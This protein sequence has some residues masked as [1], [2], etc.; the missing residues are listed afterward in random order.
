MEIEINDKV[1][2]I[3]ND[4]RF[5]IMELM[6]KSPEDPKYMKLFL[7]EILIPAPTAKELF[8]FRR[9][10]IVRLMDIFNKMDSSEATEFKKKRSR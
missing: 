5:G 7:K 1:Y 3:D 9:S 10:D 8:N 2:E 4:P 6:Q